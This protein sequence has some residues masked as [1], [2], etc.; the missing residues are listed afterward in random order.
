MR[1]LLLTEASA[2]GVGRHVMDLGEALTAAGHQCCILYGS[3]RMDQRFATRVSQFQNSRAMAIS[4]NPNL[5]DFRV[6][7]QIRG[8]IRKH[9][10]F[11]ILHAHSTKAGLLLRLAAIGFPGAVIYTPHAPLTMNPALPRLVRAVIAQSER[12]LSFL[13]DRVIAVS[14]EEA[15]HLWECG[16]PK[17]KVCVVP[18]GIAQSGPQPEPK[19]ANSASVCI[20][21]LG[22]LSPQKNAGLLIAAFALV[23][24]SHPAVSLT[25]AGTGPDQAALRKQVAGLGLAD[26]VTWLNGTEGNAMR[27]F[28]IFALPSSY[29]GMPYV[30]LEALAAGLPVVATAVGGVRSVIQHGK[31]GFVTTP[32]DVE[33]FA[34]AL[35]TLVAD[36]LLRKRCSEFA[37]VKAARFTLSRMAQETV[38]VYRQA[39]GHAKQLPLVVRTSRIPAD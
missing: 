20:G 38:S 8:Y 3:K 12:A 16:L 9:G 2:A 4:K 1:I 18:N 22:R 7:R 15:H 37:Q 34:L 35:R 36:P 23:L 30:L 32:G 5:S 21:F 19:A 6:A 11:D 26:R 14:Y 27:S 17:R 28:D 10:P 24:E 25:I 33:Q 39:I 13:T 31:E 29:E